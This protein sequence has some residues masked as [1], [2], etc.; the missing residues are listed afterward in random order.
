LWVNRLQIK[1]VKSPVLAF[2][3]AFYKNLSCYFIFLL[4]K[5]PHRLLFRF[6]LFLCQLI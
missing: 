3:F 1:Q 6:F 5:T 2:F 4:L